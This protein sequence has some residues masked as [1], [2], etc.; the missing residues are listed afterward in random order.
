M[1]FQCFLADLF[2]FVCL[3]AC[4]FYIIVIRP[5]QRIQHRTDEQQIKAHIISFVC[6]INFDMA[7]AAH[8]IRFGFGVESIR[9]AFASHKKKYI[10]FIVTI[11]T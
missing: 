5:F 10:K 2:I 6:I 3:F 8:S 9:G 1:V 11:K 4:F 7:N